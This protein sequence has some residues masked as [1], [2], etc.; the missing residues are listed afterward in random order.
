MRLTHQI[1][2]DVKAIEDTL[3][4][5]SPSL[6]EVEQ[7]IDDVNAVLAGVVIDLLDPSPLEQRVMDTA[8]WLHHW[9]A[10]LESGHIAAGDAA[11]NA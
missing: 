9:A 3:M 8:H 11:P 2:D 6:A 10:S 7:G 5:K 4:D 1:A